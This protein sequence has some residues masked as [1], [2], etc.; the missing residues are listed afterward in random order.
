MLGASCEMQQNK[1]FVVRLLEDTARVVD[2]AIETY[3]TLEDA[4]LQEVLDHALAPRG[5]RERPLL[6]RLS[7]EAVGGEFPEIIP[8]AVA[9]ELVHFS[10]LVIDDILDESPLRQGQQTVCAAYG[11]K[12]AIIVAELLNS[13]ALRALRDLYSTTPIQPIRVREA[14]QALNQAYSRVYHGQYLD[15][16]SEGG[17]AMGEDEYLYMI[18]ETTGALIT[19][20]VLL[21]AI[22]AGAPRQSIDCLAAYGDA[23]GKAFQIRDDVLD[24]V[25][26][27][28]VTGKEQGRDIA[29]GK[30]RLPVIRAL[31]CGSDS[32]KG[33]IRQV[34][35]SGRVEGHG[36]TNCIRA[37]IEAGAIQYCK[38]RAD[39]FCAESVASL[40][41]LPGTAAKEGLTAL[42]ELVS[43]SWETLDGQ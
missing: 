14:E 22:L 17:Q 20:S 1:S 25:G 4:C 13:L 37:I 32:Q 9:V 16:V 40:R 43:S 28:S 33:I 7:C 41:P 2:P 24:V 27:S 26:D 35:Q 11:A 5:M 10:T 29:Q 36:L 19:C 15:L 21:G 12:C 18:S 42:A 23:L 31:R 39:D 30:M 34:I 8:A 3:A 6:V 38:K